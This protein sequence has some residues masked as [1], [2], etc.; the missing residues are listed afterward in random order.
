MKNP[1]DEVPDLHNPIGSG[2]LATLS[3]CVEY[4]LK[5]KIKTQDCMHGKE[6]HF[7][8]DSV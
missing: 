2:N 3:L 7:H 1:D 6:R 8:R 5:K 4:D